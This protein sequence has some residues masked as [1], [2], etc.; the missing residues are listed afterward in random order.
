MKKYMGNVGGNRLIISLMV[1]FQQLINR[2]CACRSDLDEKTIVKEVQT[3]ARSSVATIHEHLR[4]CIKLAM[5]G[6][7]MPWEH[8]E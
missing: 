5:K 6:E 8:S 7:P 4:H 2:L 1:E 3:L